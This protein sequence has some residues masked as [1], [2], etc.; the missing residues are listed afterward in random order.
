MNEFRDTLFIPG[1]ASYT[2]RS[3]YQDL[4]GLSVLHCHILDHQDQGMMVPIKLVQPGDANKGGIDSSSLLVQADYPAPGL[5]LSTFPICL[6]T[7]M[8][9]TW[10]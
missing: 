6:V 10:N 2:I 1:G 5:A 3:R 8:P 9:L 4:T 7:V